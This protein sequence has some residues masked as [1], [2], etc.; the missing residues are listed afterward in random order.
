MAATRRRIAEAHRI[1]AAQRDQLH[2]ELA[3]TILALCDRIHVEKNSYRSFQK[4]YGRSVANAAPSSFLARLS[5]LAA[6]AGVPVDELPTTLRLSQV[7]HGCATIAKKP[8]RQ[9]VHDC[10]CGVRAQRDVYSAW[11][12]VFAT[13]TP[14]PSGPGW[15]LDAK[16]L[17]RAWRAAGSR[18]RASSSPVTAAAFC[19]AAAGRQEPTSPVRFA[20]GHPAKGRSRSPRSRPKAVDAREVYRGSD[21]EGERGRGCR[22]P[23][24]PRL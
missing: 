22:V 17:D 15:E 10:P 13:D 9:R 14:G 6:S 20:D 5:R 21:P 11:L 18:L 23:G 3:H 1:L 16:R 24:T 4:S 12:A 19:A 7:C 2:G 8:L